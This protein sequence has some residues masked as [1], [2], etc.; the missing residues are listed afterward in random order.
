MTDMWVLRFGTE[1]AFSVWTSSSCGD[2]FE[3]AS[4]W[5]WN[6]YVIGVVFV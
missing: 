3:R 4:V 6:V 2:K 1:A 5:M